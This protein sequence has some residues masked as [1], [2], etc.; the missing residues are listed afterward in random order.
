MVGASATG[1][2]SGERADRRLSEVLVTL[3]R[4]VLAGDDTGWL[5][6]EAVLTVATALDADRCEL[7]RPAPGGK[8]LLRVASCGEDAGRGGRDAVPRG[9]SSVAGYALL[10][11]TPVASGNLEEEKRFGVV[12]APGRSGPVSAVAAPFSWGTDSGVLVAYAARAGAF[13]ARHALSV[14]RIASLLGAALRRLEEREELRRRVEE[15]GKRP[16]KAYE[17]HDDDTLGAGEPG[18]TDRQLQVLGLMADG[19]SAKQIGSEL[20][21]SIHTVH[22]H[23]RNLYRALGVGSLAGAL[24]RAAELNLLG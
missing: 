5:A 13:D 15:S 16:R 11:G 14:G 24:K 18:L 23:Q 6:R 3:A 21:L 2:G 22:S 9:I 19:R 12:G 1:T 7:L 8:R 10:C 20:G 4:L 17:N